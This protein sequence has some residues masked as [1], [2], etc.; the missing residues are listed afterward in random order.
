MTT[1]KPNVRWVVA[2][3]AVYF[4]TLGALL[5]WTYLPRYLK[6]LG[7]SADTMGLVF[8]LGTAVQVVATPLWTARAD[9]SGAGSGLVKVAFLLG[10]T[11]LLALPHVESPVAIVA[12]LLMSALSWASILPV[13]DTLALRETDVDTFGRVRALGSLGFGISAGFA[14]FVG[15]EHSHERVAQLAPWGLSVLMAAAALATL[16]LPR[17]SKP[18][19]DTSLRNLLQ[20]LRNPTLRAAAPLWALHWASHA[21]YHLFLVFLAE[22]KGFGAW[23]PGVAVVV[24]IAA[25][26]LVLARGGA[27][28]RRFQ[29]MQAFAFCVAVT[30]IR[31]IAS[32]AA[33]TPAVLIGLQALHGVSFAAF[34]LSAIA[35][36]DREIEPQARS[37]GQGLLYVTVFGLGTVLGNAGAGAVQEA[38][39]ARVLFQAAGAAEVGLLVV[40]LLALPWF[41]RARHRQ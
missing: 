22:E 41:S 4:G 18:V 26:M 24:S 19:G 33:P 7:W 34:F 30:G 37:T 28:I 27:I 36:L 35:C 6:T 15:L 5:F 16:G 31:W 17:A 12:I 3:S 32:A 38:W 21:P 40:V 20:P 13:V 39:G 2:L 23:T 25:E 29:P 8:A 1:A 11:A 14:A 9:R 10:A